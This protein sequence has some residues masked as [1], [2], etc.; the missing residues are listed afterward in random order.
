MT[1]AHSREMTSLNWNAPNRKATVVGGS[2]QVLG[3][4]SDR[5]AV[6]LLLLAKA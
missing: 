6:L 5:L 2:R 1:F 3:I 4:L